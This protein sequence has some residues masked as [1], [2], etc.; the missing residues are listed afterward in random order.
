MTTP[1][2]ELG[3][4]ALFPDLEATAYLNH[5]A[6][7]PVSRPVRDEMVRCIEDLGRRGLGAYFDWFE[8]R[9]RLKAKLGTLIGA[10]ASDLALVPSTTRGIVDVAMCFPFRAGERV[11]VFSGEFPTNV[12]PWQRAAELFELDVVMLSADAYRRDEE[13]AL[14]ELTRELALGGVR[15]VAVSAVEFQTGYRMPLRAMADAC[16]AAGAELFVDA[17]QALGVVP[18]DVE[19]DAIDYLVCGSH[20]WLMAVE[21]IAFVYAR[22]RCAERLVPRVAG[23]LSH[24]SPV[25]FL[26]EGE[27]Q[28]RYDR[29]VRRSIDFLESSSSSTVGCAGLEASV[30]LLL[31]LTPPAVFAH[32]QRYLDLLEPALSELSFES[33]R[34]NAAEGRSGILA[35]TPPRGVDVMALAKSLQDAGISCTAP[36][37]RLRFS[38][39]WP[40]HGDEIAPVLAAV[41]T[42]LRLARIG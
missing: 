26:L 3:S 2:A 41:K 40:N 13:Q 6:M 5:A 27:G 12:T 9:Q 17:I 28:L 14:E 7:S 22:A 8:Q 36:D 38:P 39:H 23:W 1:R 37:G 24:E 31:Q 30:D 35:L 19:A 34:A 4:R 11:I 18:V 16:H 21:G 20:K 29:P 15:V 10:S 33:L 32:V 25:S 42:S